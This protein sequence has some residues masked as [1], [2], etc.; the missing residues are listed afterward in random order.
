MAE[1]RP[2]SAALPR[3]AR[4]ALRRR[5][6]R[7]GA[8]PRGHFDHAGVQR[9]VRAARQGRGVEEVVRLVRVRVRVRVRV[10]VRLRVR[11]RVRV[12]VRVRVRG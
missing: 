7:A 9:A 10:G 11:V 4:R 6:S 12:K 8:L 1:L 5:R 3:V 2:G